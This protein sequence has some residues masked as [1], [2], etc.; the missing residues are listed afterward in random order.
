MIAALLILI[1]A[2]IW[3]KGGGLLESRQVL[4][5]LFDDVGGLSVGDP[6]V[7]RGVKQGA[8]EKVALRPDGVTVT[9]W[10]YQDLPL[11]SDLG[12]GIEDR[13]LMGGRQI[14][15]D[16]GRSGIPA[17]LSL[18]Y[19]GV[20]ATG[21]LSMMRQAETM[22]VYADSLL[23]ATAA[24]IDPAAVTSLLQGLNR[25]ADETSRILR[26]NRS[27][28][29]Q[30]IARAAAVTRSLEQDSLSWRTGLL[31]DRL[32]RLS[33]RLDS[34]SA[35]AGRVISGL[36]GSEGTAGRLLQDQALYDRLLQS[37]AGIDSLITD[38][39]RHPRRYFKITVF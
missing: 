18:V 33:V 9:F 4:T 15:F 19:K 23:H 36:A 25:A 39:R 11:Y 29:R 20:N 34:T 10:V 22:L 16:P 6:V 27:D 35:V 14:S 24:A 7:V 31:L 12:A 32:D 13:E 30:S 1:F 3:G 2:L 37:A 17:D 26:E 38:I 5:F 21:I 8:V 28:I